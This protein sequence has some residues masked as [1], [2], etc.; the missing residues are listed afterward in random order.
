M[1]VDSTDIKILYELANGKSAK[2]IGSLVNLS[3]RTVEVR[4]RIMR[5][6]YDCI[7][8]TNLVATALRNKVFIIF[9]KEKNNE[10]LNN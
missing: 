6:K 4:I 3:N 9:I 8:S 10:L 7:N 1:T 5:Y 2:E